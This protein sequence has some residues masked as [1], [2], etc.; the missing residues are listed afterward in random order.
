MNKWLGKIEFSG[1]YTHRILRTSLDF[2]FNQSLC[3]GI[4]NLLPWT[5]L[6]L[7]RSI[8]FE[9][10]KKTRAKS[11]LVHSFFF[12]PFIPYLMRKSRRTVVGDFEPAYASIIQIRWSSVNFIFRFAA[13]F[14]RSKCNYSK[15]RCRFLVNL[16]Q[17][18]RIHD[19]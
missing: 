13:F 9:M 10:Q 3:L 6:S 12:I 5:L 4:W 18:S 19:P 17:K 7:H 14:I 11:F 16:Y 1:Y 15:T 8:L 2:N